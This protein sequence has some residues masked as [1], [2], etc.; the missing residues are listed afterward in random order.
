MNQV[1]VFYSG[2]IS[3]YLS[4][5][6][7]CEEYGKENVT[8]LF[9]DVCYEHSSL[10][11]FL[12]EGHNLLGCEMVYL[13][14]GRTP[15]DVFKD[16]KLMGNTR[17]DPCSRVLK[18]EPSIKYVKENAPN[19]ILCIGYDWT[20][21]GRIKKAKHHWDNEVICPLAAPPYMT[22]KQM[23]DEVESDGL[24]IPYLYGIGMAHNNCSGFCVKAGQGHYS[25]L[26]REDRKLYM[27][28]EASE[29]SV[30]DCLG[31]TNPFL[32]VTV[33]GLLNYMTLRQFREHLESS[34][35]Y[36]LFDIGGC[37]CFSE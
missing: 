8:L 31:K 19:H 28:H 15:F 5:K 33:N 6:R 13:K 27:Q 35:Q 26:L 11:K 3:S 36:D 24:E 37:G 16:V 1:L 29:Q 20:E 12:H 18:R 14:D 22:K 7:C 32:R 34:G 4:A 21:N 10:Y 17:I 2:G 9:T 25:V 23:L 30:Y